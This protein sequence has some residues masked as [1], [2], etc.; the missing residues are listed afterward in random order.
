MVG[1][2]GCDDWFHFSCLKISSNYKEL[3]FSFFCPYCQA[4]I[5]GPGSLS[6]GNLPKT[7][8]KRKC[9]LH[10]CYK[11][12]S[13]NSK[14]CSEQHAEE[15]IGGVLRRVESKERNSVSLT[16]QM[17][18]AGD[19]SKIQLLGKQGIP[20]ATREQNSDLYDSLIGRDKKLKELREE[21]EIIAKKE[22]PRIEQ[23]MK[24]LKEY[25]EWLKAVNS[26]LF[27]SVEEAVSRKSQKKKKALKR[28][29]ICGYRSQL[30]IPCSVEDFSAQFQEDVEELHDICCRMRCSRHQDW[31]GTMQDAL[32]FQIE[33]FETSSQRLALLV[34]IREDQLNSQFHEQMQRTADLQH[35]PRTEERVQVAQLT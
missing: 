25:S 5:T 26:R 10:S 32:Q 11:P 15:Y 17:L 4:G 33:S 7:I 21:Q 28:K 6:S 3:V 19:L 9:R 20:P 18:E 29:S 13:E 27:D 34:K 12:C 8:W 24:A 1:C 14:Y 30:T 31:A 23:E 35:A 22:M 2:D 16:R